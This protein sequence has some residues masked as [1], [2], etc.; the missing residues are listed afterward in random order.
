MHLGTSSLAFYHIFCYSYWMHEYLWASESEPSYKIFGVCEHLYSVF[1]H[2][3]SLKWK[4]TSILQVVLF[5]I[6]CLMHITTLEK[7]WWRKIL[8]QIWKLFDGIKWVKADMTLITSCKFLCTFVLAHWSS[9][10]LP[11]DVKN[12]TTTIITHANISHTIYTYTYMR[13]YVNP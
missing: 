1:D 4:A 12:I 8:N 6:L 7:Y 13:S 11:E 10:W 3:C 5:T 2:D 9:S